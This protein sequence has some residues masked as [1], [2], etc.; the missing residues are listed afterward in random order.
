M[1]VVLPGRG[2]G[3]V[4][5]NAPQIFLQVAGLVVVDGQDAR[6]GESLRGKV[7]CQVDEAVVL[8]HR[9]ADNADDRLSAAP[10]Q[11]HIAAVAPRFG[12]GFGLERCR[13][14]PIFI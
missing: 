8:A 1:V 6:H 14:A 11:A 12:K 4:E 10:V 7:A 13:A 5:R 2:E 9:S 3:I